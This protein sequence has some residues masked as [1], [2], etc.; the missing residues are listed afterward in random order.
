MPSLLS[1]ISA[2]SRLT[3]LLAVSLIVAL[4]IFYIQ[5]SLWASP[6]QQLLLE[7]QTFLLDPS[8]NHHKGISTN[9]HEQQSP[10]YGY[11]RPRVVVSLSTFGHRITRILNT[12]DSIYNQTRRPDAL[13]LHIPD[14]IERIQAGPVD[15]TIVNDL[16]AKYDGWLIHQT[17]RLSPRRKDPETIIITV[18]DD[19]SY[20]ED[21]VK[22]L[23]GAIELHSNAIPCFVCEVWYEERSMYFG[24]ED[25]C[26]G[27]GNAFAGMAYRVRYFDE[28]VFNYEG[29]PDGC[30]LHDDVYLS[31]WARQ[32]GYKPFVVKPGF[33]SIIHEEGHTNLSINS[34]PSTE[35]EYRNPC[36]EHFNYFKD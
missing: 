13:Y 27:W 33:G 34:V 1:G 5:S 24:N 4:H 29:V 14:K 12:I 36:V 21:V 10:S 11:I 19:T 16:V 35:N 17:S 20:H 32:R 9:Q 25:F 18:D 3:I 28:N 31:G 26:D 15:T 30:T 7:Q 6:Q 22:V 23:V 2:T 8:T